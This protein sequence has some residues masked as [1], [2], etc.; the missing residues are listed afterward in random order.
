MDTAWNR[1]RFLKAQEALRNL[2]DSVRLG[3]VQWVAAFDVSFQGRRGYGVGALFDYE[4]LAMSECYSVS[5]DAYV[6]YVPTFL[7]FREMPYILS[8]WKR[9]TRKPDLML[10]DGHGLSHPRAM[11]I[12]TQAGLACRT[13]SIGI[14]KK[15]LF[16]LELQ[17]EEGTFLVHPETGERLAYVYKH[18][19]RFN[20][21]YISVGVGMDLSTA[22]NVVLKLFRG[23]REPEPLRAV[24]NVSLN[25]GR[26]GLHAV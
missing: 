11:G 24:H 23:C 16:G 12:A 4:T 7:A 2:T 14:A 17:T 19:P 18:K 8:I 21:V 25:E 15:P 3:S 9:F 13:P 5:F 26:I 6:P 20:P 1:E 22:V 10:I